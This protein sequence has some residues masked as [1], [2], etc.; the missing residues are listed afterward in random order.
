MGAGEVVGAVDGVGVGVAIGALGAS[1]K[2]RR[3]GP[4]PAGAQVAVVPSKSKEQTSG[5]R[6]VHGEWRAEIVKV[7]EIRVMTNASHEPVGV[8]MVQKWA[9]PSVTSYPVVSAEGAVSTVKLACSESATNS[10]EAVTVGV[11]RAAA[12]A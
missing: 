8:L 3:E 7:A 9:P 5:T 4:A 1:F 11:P 2:E 10:L 6:E 12:C